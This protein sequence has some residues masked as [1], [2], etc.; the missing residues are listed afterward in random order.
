MIY[1]SIEMQSLCFYL[2]VTFRTHS[3]FATEAGVKYF[4]LGAFA[5]GI[6]LFGI[7]L[8]YGFTGTTNFS[9]LQLL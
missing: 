8:I 9:T 6:L 4:I 1:L 2:L 7:S 5:S 3:K